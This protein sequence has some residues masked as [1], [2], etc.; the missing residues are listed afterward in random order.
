VNQSSLAYPVSMELRDLEMPYK[1]NREQWLIEI[2][3]TEY[4]VDEIRAGLWYKR[5]EGGL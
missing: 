4:T 2:S 1:L 5:L 3:H